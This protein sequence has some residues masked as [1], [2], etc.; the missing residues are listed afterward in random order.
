MSWQKAIKVLITIALLVGAGIWGFKWWKGEDKTPEA[1]ASTLKTAQVTRGH[2]RQ[3]VSSPGSVVSNLDVEIKCRASGEVIKLPFDLSDPV[4]K[5]DLL[6]EL[7]P[8]DQERLVQQS[9]ASLS[10]SEARLAQ[11]KSSLAAAEQALIADRQKASAAVQAA[12]VRA[13]DAAAKAEREA[14][15][16]EKKYSSQEGVETAQTTAAQAKQELQTAKAQ[17]ESLK[18]QELS[19]ETSRQQI[20]LAEAQVESDKIAL[21]LANR[22]LGYTKVFSP[23]DGVVAK[24][25]A[26][27]G[28]I[29]SSGI[30]NVGGGTTVLTLS[31]L[32]RIFI[33]TSVDEADIGQIKIGQE[34]E[35]TADSFQ[36]VKFKGRVDRIATN[37]LNVQNVVT[38]EVRVEVLG[39]NKSLLKPMMT[40]TVDILIADK[41]DILVVPVEAVD[42]KGGAHV[43]LAKSDGTPGERKQIEVGIHDKDNLEVVSGL[44]EGDSVIVRSLEEDSRWR[45]ENGGAQND[46]RRR[47]M[48][49]RT[50]GG[51]G[52]R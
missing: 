17:L 14:Q 48:M 31:D 5:G 10:A 19:L 51:G 25:T 1:E 45:A 50:I 21:S 18:A 38:F 2:I 37:G 15:L 16:L 40:T 4:K 30:S 12:E 49:M 44:S 52:R 29:I 11:A 35:V 22:Q 20:K 24:R 27:I 3:V 26:Q 46:A 23:I 34:A 7:D 6:L 41:Q 39:D 43:E 32:S 28:Q 8:V 33:L 47:M 9:Q 13:R 42:Q 36:G